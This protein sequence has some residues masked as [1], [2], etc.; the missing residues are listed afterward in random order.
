MTPILPMSSAFR[1]DK[2]RK[3]PITTF[4]RALLRVRDDVTIEEINAD[5]ANALTVNVGSNDE[6]FGGVREDSY[7]AKT[8]AAKD[9]EMTGR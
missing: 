2:N 8:I 9:S 6:I 4:I 1:I 7:L 3:L 5:L